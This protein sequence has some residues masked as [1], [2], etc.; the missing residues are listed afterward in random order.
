M[1][2]PRFMTIISATGPNA[3]IFAIWFPVD[4][5]DEEGDEEED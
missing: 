2:R 3:N 4:L 1:P 5:G